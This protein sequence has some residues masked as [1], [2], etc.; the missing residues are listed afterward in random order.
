MS[1]SIASF[2]TT[3]LLIHLC[4]STYR[5]LLLCHGMISRDGRE[6]KDTESGRREIKK[7][8]DEHDDQEPGLLEP[9]NDDTSRELNEGFPALS[10]KGSSLV[11]LMDRAKNLLVWRDMEDAEGGKLIDERGIKSID[12]SG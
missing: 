1:R 8:S 7:Y 5:Y 2:P 4:K 9:L 6:P 10:Q 3:E 11:D 12:H